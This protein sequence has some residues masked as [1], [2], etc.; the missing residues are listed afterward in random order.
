MDRDHN[1]S[2]TLLTEG[3]KTVG[4][5]RIEFTPVEILT[6]TLALMECFNSIPYVKARLVAEAG[7]LIAL[8]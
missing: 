1:S 3:L 5:E 6:S 8:A 4:M 2:R 7:S